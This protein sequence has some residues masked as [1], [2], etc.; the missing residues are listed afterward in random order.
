MGFEG[1]E[2][3]LQFTIAGRDGAFF[4][5]DLPFTILWNG[6]FQGLLPVCSIDG[7]YPEG[8]VVFISKRPELQFW[9]WSG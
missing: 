4:A 1:G 2:R 5:E 7:K 6:Q 9:Y 3:V 8:A